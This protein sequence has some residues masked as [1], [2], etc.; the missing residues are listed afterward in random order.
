MNRCFGS[1]YNHLTVVQYLGKETEY[2]GEPHGNRKNGFRPHQRTKPSVLSKIKLSGD[3]NPK[4]VKDKHDSENMVLAKL[5]GISSV[6]NNKQIS[7][8]L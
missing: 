5:S 1:D 4:S 7:N 2:K 8:A 3:D 6:R